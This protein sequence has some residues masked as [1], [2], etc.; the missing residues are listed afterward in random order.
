M[1][2]WLVLGGRGRL[3]SALMEIAPIGSEAP[4][5]ETLNLCTTSALARKMDQMEP[6]R[7]INC[8]A[9]TDVDQCESDPERAHEINGVAVGRLARAC[10]DREI[11]LCQISTDYVLSG[12]G[13]LHEEQAYDP[14]NCYGE[15]KALGEQLC[16]EASPDHLVAR[17]QWLFGGGS[18]DFIRFVGDRALSNQVIPVI[19]DQVSS[20]S[21]TRD[22]A[23][24]IRQLFKA[25]AN[26]I[27]HIANA[28][29]TSRWDQALSICETLEIR[30]HLKPV[31]WTDLGRPAKR[32]RRSV[33]DT[34]HAVA[35]TGHLKTDCLTSETALPGRKGMH[36]RPWQSAQ[37]EWLEQ[38]KC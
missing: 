25:Q 14:V 38:L 23:R 12:D 19:K 13:L 22:L 16:L 5:S 17:V 8:A 36:P 33:L 31:T 27:V 2:G 1:T 28:G 29:E 24:W 30:A 37:D 34:A 18:S 15:S 32:P 3:G 4:S 11:Q 35:L 26:G 21:Y 9:L 20:P 10:A 6:T 7:V